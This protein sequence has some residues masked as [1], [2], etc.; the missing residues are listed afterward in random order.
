MSLAQGF[1]MKS[2]HFTVRCKHYKSEKLR[3]IRFFATDTA[4]KNV[5]HVTMRRDAISYWSF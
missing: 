3:V 1:E 4:I 5:S 2:L